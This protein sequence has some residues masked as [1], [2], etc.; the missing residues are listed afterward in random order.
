MNGTR[1]DDDRV[2]AV[3]SA[4][5][6]PTRRA[7][8]RSLS[9]GGPATLAR[10]AEKLPVTRQA[11]SKHLAALEQAGLVT[12]TAAGRRRT[13]RL[14]PGPLTEAMGWMVDVGAEWDSRLDALR[15]YVE[16]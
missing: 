6:D 11:V 4:L 5:S 14:T 2:D 13:Y 3:F 12:A 9:D 7:V 8:I 16:R 1:D 15:R 10:L